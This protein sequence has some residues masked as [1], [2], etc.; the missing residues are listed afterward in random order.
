[1]SGNLGAVQN[2]GGTYTRPTWHIVVDVCF[3]SV[4]TCELVVAEHYF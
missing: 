4:F 1:V 3:T 2:G